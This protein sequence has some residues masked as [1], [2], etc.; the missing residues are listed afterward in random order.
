[1]TKKVSR[2]SRWWT[3]FTNFE[4]WPFDVFYFPVKFYYLFLSIRSRSLFFFTASN[5]SI[6]FGGMLGE[7][8]SEIFDLIPDEYIPIT[9][10]FP[11]HVSKEEV[12]SHLSQMGLSFPI[13]S[14]P[15]VGERGW[16]VAKLDSEEELTQYLQVI[17]V[18]FL[19]QE[20]IDYPIE[21]GVFFIKVP[22]ESQGKVT[23]IVKKGF[24]TVTGDG[25]SNVQEL[26]EQSVRAVLQVDFESTEVLAKAND[27]PKK[28]ENV[29]IESIGNH[30]RGTTFLNY[31][32][33]INEEL[34]AAFNKISDQIKDFHFGRFDLKCTSIES[35]RQVKEFKIL[36]LNGA[37]SEP[38]HVY[39]PGNSIFQAYRDIFWHLKMLRKV[40]SA[41]HKRGQHYW[42]FSDGI[43]KMREIYAYNKQKGSPK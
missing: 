4:F 11:P 34:H 6:E 32:D 27:I 15:D 41:N 30:C 39:H 24:L 19:I 23:S 26:L 18:D 17:E 10:L 8:K 3:R 31:N 43:K 14:K 9:R 28:G 22:G 35:L 5:P 13:I 37:G 40:S 7:K 12:L 21:L 1:M 16:M 33:W 2:F 25:K 29:L 36:E 42:K 38:G 20:F